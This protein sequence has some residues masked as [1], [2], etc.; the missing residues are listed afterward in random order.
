MALRRLLSFSTVTL[1]ICI[2]LSTVTAQ[3]PT[4][5]TFARGATRATARGYLRG[6]R[7][8]VVF[9][10]ERRRINTCASSSMAAAPRAA[11]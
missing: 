5:I 7:D 1:T 2:T 6:V 8:E 11:L 9:F 4:R 10:C 3:T